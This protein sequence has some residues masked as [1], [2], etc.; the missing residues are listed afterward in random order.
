VWL[1]IDKKVEV[2][3]NIYLDELANAI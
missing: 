2:M 3:A 1:F